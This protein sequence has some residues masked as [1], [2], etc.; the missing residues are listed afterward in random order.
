M[1]E[2]RRPTVKFSAVSQVKVA[3]VPVAKHPEE[4]SSRPS[5]SHHSVVPRHPSFIDQEWL[6]SETSVTRPTETSIEAQPTVAQRDRA[7]LP[8]LTGLNAGQVFTI[9]ADETTIGRGREATIRVEDVGISRAHSRILR[10]MDGKYYVEDLKSTNGTFV[11]GTQIDRAEL[12]T[13]DRV[14][15]G[16]N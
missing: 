15:V 5:S 2:D 7:I 11:A 6:D 3:E 12:K 8:V 1:A 4:P 9:D 13:G 16:P 10:T 14:Q